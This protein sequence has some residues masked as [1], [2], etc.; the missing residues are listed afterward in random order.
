MYAAIQQIAPQ[1]T[2]RLFTGD[3]VDHAVWLVSQSQNMVDINGAYT[4]MSG[5]PRVY[6]VLGNHE[7]APVNAYPPLG[8]M[9]LPANSGFM[10]RLLRPGV[11]GLMLQ[12]N[13]KSTNLV[14]T[15]QKYRIAISASY[16]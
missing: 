13:K 16:R 5:L 10:M 8:W 7:A 11:N 6:G 2:L 3:I 1:A 4:R 9:L 15:H 12:R 14:H